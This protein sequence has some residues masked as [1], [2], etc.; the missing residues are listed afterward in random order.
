MSGGTTD[1]AQ[2]VGS[3]VGRGAAWSLLNTVV[4]KLGSFAAGV[5]L[6]RL[7]A[8]EDYGV[9]AVALVVLT[10]LHAFNELGVSLA[11]VQWPD[12]ERR[13]APTVM[14]IALTSST[15]LY[16]LAY[17]G[18]PALSDVMGAP[19]ATPVLRLLCLAVIVDGVAAVPVG[20]LTRHF[21]HVRRLV[22]D[23]ASFTASTTVTI[24]LAAS[25]AGPLSF[26]W[27]TLAGSVLATVVFTAL[28][29]FRVRPGWDRA[30]APRLLRFGLPLAGASLLVLSVVNADNLVVGALT[31]PAALGLYLMA[32]NQS[33][34]P[35]NVFGE[36]ARRVALAGFSRLT[37]NPDALSRAFA[38][39]LG[40]LMAVTV[41]VCALL[42][43]YADSLLRFVYGAP[44]APAAQALVF[45]A[46]LGLVRVGLFVVYDL[47]VAL[48]RSRVLLK[49]QGLWL[50][51]MVPAL[52]A[53]TAIG[54]IR[55]AAI[56]HLLVAVLVIAPVFL[57]AVATHGIAV[58]PALR[59][60]LRPALGGLLIV[61]TALLVRAAV[62]EDLPRLLLGGLLGLA[63]HLPV[64]WPMR[65]LLPGRSPAEE[66]TP[67]PGTTA[68]PTAVP[69]VPPAAGLPAGEM[70]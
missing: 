25:G 27:G 13:I 11:L 7:L 56:A 55:G 49:V 4:L 67:A 46:P 21:L 31:G 26:A 15:V 20:L 34:W 50:V 69:S 3:R 57:R 14:T 30:L 19:D 43:C 33:S 62:D 63:V 61:A 39:G 36:A 58:G 35:L 28:A 51:L 48:D 38:R 10:L 54:G 5:V 52:A 70:R 9:Y 42:A 8:P 6:A 41:P 22:G 60:C 40:L 66:P 68:L 18:A 12:D 47:F 16:L 24:G 17:A 53:G 29:P 2:G 32:F 64:V 44:W 1:P 65:T 37:G 23:V 59:S 45:L